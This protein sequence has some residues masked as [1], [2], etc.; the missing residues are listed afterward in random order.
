MSL[1]LTDAASTPVNRA[2]NATQSDPDLT[3]WK[4]F[5]TNGGYPVGAGVASASVKENGNGTIRV[6]LKLSLPTMETLSGDTDLGFTPVPTKA[7]DCIGSVELVF[8]NRASLQNRKDL[9][10][11]LADFLSDA[12]VTS[13]VEDFV[14]FTG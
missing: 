10:A 3:I 9:K 1:T 2:F 6:Q 14:H 4:D 8:P 12:K 5:A 11:M 13:A 7:F